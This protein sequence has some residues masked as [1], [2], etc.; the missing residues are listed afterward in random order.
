ML[1]SKCISVR[2]RVCVTFSLSRSTMSWMSEQASVS[3]KLSSLA[4]LILLLS[5][6][7]C[8]RNSC[9][10]TGLSRMVLQT[11]ETLTPTHFHACN[12]LQ[13]L[14]PV[15]YQIM[16]PGTTSSSTSWLRWLRTACLF[17]SR[18]FML[19]DCCCRVWISLLMEDRSL[20]KP[21]SMPSIRWKDHKRSRDV[22]ACGLVVW[23]FSGLW[24]QDRD[25]LSV[26]PFQPAV[27]YW[28]D[29]KGLISWGSLSW[30]PALVQLLCCLSVR[31][32]RRFS[33]RLF[34]SSWTSSFSSSSSGL[35]CLRFSPNRSPLGASFLVC[36]AI[37]DSGS[38]FQFPLKETSQALS[39][40][41]S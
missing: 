32:F 40:L 3:L 27:V 17:F 22:S 13:Q 4:K 8:S 20:W 28:T 33:F 37:W 31:W 10:V 24:E 1:L 6:C 29:W 5:S 11:W 19:T 21:L 9:S 25:V 26:A 16:A 39:L 12:P 34:S 38:D 30:T 35:C 36:Y 18:T 14:S 2:A 15:S 41:L 7:S 23:L